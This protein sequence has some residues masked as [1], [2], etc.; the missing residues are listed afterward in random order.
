MS[1]DLDLVAGAPERVREHLPGSIAAK[2][3][4]LEECATHYAVEHG[5]RTIG[6]TGASGG[7][8]AKLVKIPIRIPSSNVQHIQEAHITIG[9]IFCDLIEQTLCTGL[10]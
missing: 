9:H 6:L 3:R 2:Q 5:I 7:E 1:E 10:A 8:L 4:V